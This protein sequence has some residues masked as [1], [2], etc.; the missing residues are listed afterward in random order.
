[1]NREVLLSCVNREVVL[2]CVNKEVVLSC[3]NREVVLGFCRMSV[4]GN[5]FAS[6]KLF[7][8]VV[9]ADIVFVPYA[10]VETVSCKRERERER[11][12]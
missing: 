11:E 1:M 7:S 2:N 4:L 8:T 5:P 12:L 6:V 3:V 9:F 10:M